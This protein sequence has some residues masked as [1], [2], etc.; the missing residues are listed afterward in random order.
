MIT[1]IKKLE[2][3]L[4]HERFK[5]LRRL[6]DLKSVTFELGLC[7]S[8]CEEVLNRRDE[9][10]LVIDGLVTAGL[11]RYVRCFQPNGIRY[12]LSKDDISSLTSEERQTHEY[13]CA[14][15][16]KHI[17]HSVNHY[18]NCYISLDV[19]FINGT[20]AGIYNVLPESERVVLNR[21]NAWALKSVAERVIECIRP[22]Y[23]KELEQAQNEA[24][25]ISEE[26]IF[27]LKE[28]KRLVPNHRAV[29]RTRKNG[30]QA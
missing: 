11:V 7:V 6:A 4:S 24:S 25:F 30:P 14:L 22:K 26:E 9:N 3:P 19:S 2:I 16:N 21:E 10:S 15:R 18:E 28:H 20:P 17:S 23:E 5:G 12:S 1:E 27:K 13:F 8:L 29:E